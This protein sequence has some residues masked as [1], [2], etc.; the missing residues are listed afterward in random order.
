MIGRFVVIYR[1]QA[2][3]VRSRS[4]EAVRATILKA[5]ARQDASE[6]VKVGKVVMT[7]EDIANGR[8]RVLELDAW[9]QEA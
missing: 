6:T 5:Y 9:F 4:I 2:F 1:G 3:P 8:Y 7:S